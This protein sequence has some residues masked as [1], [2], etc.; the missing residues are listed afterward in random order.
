MASPIPARAI[1]VDPHEPGDV[2]L[3]TKDQIIASGAL[4]SFP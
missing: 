2:T 4:C 1:A 3:L